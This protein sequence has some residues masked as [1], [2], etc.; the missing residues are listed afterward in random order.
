MI[1]WNSAL[2]WRSERISLSRDNNMASPVS[3]WG[4]GWRCGPAGAGNMPGQAFGATC[5]PGAATLEKE[6]MELTAAFLELDGLLV[7]AS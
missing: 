6:R 2:N 4:R 7:A 3:G 5:C 1:G